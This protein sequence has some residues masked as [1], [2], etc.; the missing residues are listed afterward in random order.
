M[1]VWVHWYTKH[2]SV[3]FNESGGTWLHWIRYQKKAVEMEFKSEAEENKMCVH[4]KVKWEKS[5]E[6]EVERVRYVSVL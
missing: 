6:G 2:F 4:F 3:L 5:G 1:E